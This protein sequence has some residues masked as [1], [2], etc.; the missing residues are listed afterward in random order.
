MPACLFLAEQ[1]EDVYLW[2]LYQAFCFIVG[3]VAQ[4]RCLFLLVVRLFKV[5][6]RKTNE[7]QKDNQMDA[8]MS[9]KQMYFF[10]GQLKGILGSTDTLKLLT[11]SFLF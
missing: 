11:K 9:A 1:K 8:I 10:N 7:L 3:L 6:T 4:G 5:Y 2:E